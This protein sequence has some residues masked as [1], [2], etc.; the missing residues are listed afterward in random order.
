MQRV[1]VGEFK[2]NTYLVV[3]RPSKQALLIDPGGNPITIEHHIRADDLL[4]QHIVLTHGH[5]D[6]ISAVAVLSERFGVRCS[7]HEAE[8]KLIRRAATYALRLAGHAVTV[9]SNMNW[10]V[11]ETRQLA[12]GDRA[13][14]V[15]PTPGHTPGSVCYALDGL[16]FTGDTLMYQQYGTTEY[17]D[18]SPHQLRSAVRALL[19]E[20]P[21][22]TVIFPGHGRPWT[23]R[24]ATEWLG[25][26]L[27]T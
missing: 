19:T 15:L 8:E 14:R 2:S 1:A 22:D 25:R 16:V 4:L 23:V 21:A 24:A 3:H 10:F 27:S 11:P 17:P 5:F 26:T 20:L 9:P 18:S 13:I 7:A 12:W 6:H